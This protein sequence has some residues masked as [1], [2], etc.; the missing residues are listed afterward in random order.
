MRAICVGTTE[1][2]ASSKRASN[3]R[4]EPRFSGSG[5]D[6]RSALGAVIG[7]LAQFLV[8]LA[9]RSKRNRLRASA[10]GGGRSQGF[11]LVP[12][13]SPTEAWGSSPWHAARFIACGGAASS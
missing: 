12:D 7:Q 5:I 8:Q 2:L 4:I 3:A 9:I 11:R 13:P 1:N 10:F 6:L